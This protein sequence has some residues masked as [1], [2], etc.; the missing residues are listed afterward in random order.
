MSH[1]Q[2]R[3]EED[4]RYGGISGSEESDEER[5]F[6]VDDNDVPISRPRKKKGYRY[7]DEAM[8]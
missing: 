2:D 8:Q 4:D 7:N 1:R 6:I 3:E 5:D